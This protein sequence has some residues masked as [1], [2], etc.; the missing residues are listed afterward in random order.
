ML[1]QCALDRQPRQLE[2]LPEPFWHVR[3]PLGA[4]PASVL[5]VQPVLR[6]E[7]LLG[8]MEMAGFRQLEENEA[9]LLQEVLPRLAGAMAIMERSEAAQALL[10]E[11]RRQAD[12][13]GAQALQLEHQAS[14][15]EAQQAALRATEAWYRGIIE[16]APDGMLVL[17]SLIHI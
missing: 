9:L 6:G 10:L 13:M 5:L 12:E 14:E 7:R 11:T 16:A 4:A 2:D 17:L 3:T 8:V 15:L 1:G